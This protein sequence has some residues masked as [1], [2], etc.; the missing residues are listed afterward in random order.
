MMNAVICYKHVQ[1]LRVLAHIMEESADF[2]ILARFTAYN[3]WL[4]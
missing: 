4:G 2:G 3:G 1:E